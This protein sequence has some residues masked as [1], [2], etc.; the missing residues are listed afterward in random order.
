MGFIQTLKRD[1]RAVFEKDPAARNVW[2]VL[3]YPGLHA[4][5]Y[6][7]FAHALWTRGVKT[8]ARWLSHWS[9]FATGIEIH[10][11]ARIGTGFFIDHG[12]GT[13]I[14]ETTIIGD[15]VLL[16]HNVTLGGT[17]LKKKKRHPTIGNGVVISPGA[18]V[19]G[20]ITVGEYAKIG[21]NA[22]VRNDVESGATVVGIPGRAVQR[23]DVQE[24]TGA[25]AAPCGDLD[26]GL[27]EDPEGVMLNCM[28]RRIQ[29]L[30]D[31][32]RELRNGPPDLS[33]PPAPLA[34]EPQLAPL[35]LEEG[36]SPYAPGH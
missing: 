34:N 6:H 5:V 14:G 28:L 27:S 30:E 18:K 23:L 22:V 33:R 29:D 1:V 11:G 4:I 36:E 32:I 24:W 21:P 35:K 13:V 20:D 8:P 16:Y 19:L 10:P 7:R 15:D 9:R 26:H 2:E 17:S 31:Q 3:S 12:M 25:N